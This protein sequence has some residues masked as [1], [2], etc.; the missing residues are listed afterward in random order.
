MGPRMFGGLFA[1]PQRQRERARSTERGA[2]ADFY[3]AD[4]P[5]ASTPA[6][7]MRLLAIDLET[8]GLN[9]QSDRA[10]SVGFVPLD[11]PDIL[12]AGARH[13]IIRAEAPAEQSEM[14]QSAVGQSAVL[15]HLTDDMIAAGLPMVEVLTKT[16][17]ALKGRV[18]LAHYAR[19]EEGFLSRACEEHF[20]APL[21]V[22]VID[23][24]QLHSRLLSQ[25]FDDE[26]RGDQ[27]RLW[28]ARE[29]Y[30]LPTYGAHEALT[31]AMACAELYLG[32]V[33]ELS[34]LK[35]Q[36]LSSLRP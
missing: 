30:G 15:H 20:G 3:A 11:G 28:N 26:A 19:I 7:E 8:T 35:T 14:G 10:L 12:L 25:G 33:A 27:L 6:G 31:D 23:T 21:V 13:M 2:L 16:L 36:T 9:P 32:Q 5:A 1:R 18:L 22:P 34:T 29:R 24:L 4:W 17:A